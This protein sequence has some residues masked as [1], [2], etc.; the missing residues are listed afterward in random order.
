[1]AWY[2]LPL[3]PVRIINVNVHVNVNVDIHVN[4]DVDVNVNVHVYVIVDVDVNNQ[5]NIKV[6][7][8]MIMW[9]MER[10]YFLFSKFSQ[11]CKK[12]PFPQFITITSKITS[13]NGKWGVRW[14]ELSTSQ[15]FTLTSSQ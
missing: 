7:M 1:M 8:I 12:T 13:P 4:V 2:L 10:F 15:F 11:W 6:W 5:V 3:L 9:W 14:R